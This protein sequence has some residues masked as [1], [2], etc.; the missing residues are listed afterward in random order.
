MARLV[1][2]PAKGPSDKPFVRL[3]SVLPLLVLAACSDDD[4]HLYL[5]NW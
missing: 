4:R 3:L 5:Q 2:S 1:C